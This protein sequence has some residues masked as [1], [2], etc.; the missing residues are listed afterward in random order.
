VLQLWRYRGH[1]RRWIAAATAFAVAC[2]LLLSAAVRG[3]A[4]AAEAGPTGELFA[5]CHGLGNDSPADP[6]PS[7]QSDY[8]THC[9][10]CTLAS[11]TWA[12]IP[13]ATASA[14]FDPGVSSE[15]ITP[16]DSQIVQV[17]S[18][19]SEYPRGPPTS[20]L[21]AEPVPAFHSGNRSRATKMACNVPASKT[22]GAAG[23][24]CSDAAVPCRHGCPAGT[25]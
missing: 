20:S 8:Q 6:Q 16:C 4:T 23:Q 18:L 11:D 22:I 19:A 10:L 21:P 13:P 17:V 3:Q 2:Q 15:L 12:V 5:I 14:A 24:L 9:V 25:A 1:G 7:K